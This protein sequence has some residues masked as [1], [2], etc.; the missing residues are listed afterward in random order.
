MQS[1]SWKLNMNDFKKWIRNMIIFLAPLLLIYFSAIV[2]K[3]SAG[4]PIVK[5]LE[6][7]PAIQGALI[8]YVLNAVIDLLRKVSAGPK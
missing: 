2:E 5:L 7:D 1:E 8:L 4:V 6:L 3:L